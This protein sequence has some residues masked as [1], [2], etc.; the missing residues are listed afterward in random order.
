M[1][2]KLTSGFTST[3]LVI[4]LFQ[5]FAS[6]FVLAATKT[7]QDEKEDLYFQI[8]LESLR[9]KDKVQV[10]TR[11]FSDPSEFYG[12]EP[13]SVVNLH[14][15][16][17][18]PKANL[19]AVKSAFVIHKSPKF[20]ETNHFLSDDFLFKTVNGLKNLNRDTRDPNRAQM[21]IETGAFL[22]KV[23]TSYTVENEFFLTRQ[24]GIPSP[25]AT[26]LA[27]LDPLLTAPNTYATQNAF[28]FSA[29]FEGIANLSQTYELSSEETLVVNYQLFSILETLIH[30]IDL[31][32]FASGAG[33][34]ASQ[35][36][37]QTVT[38]AENTE[39]Y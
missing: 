20:F 17:T 33:L 8:D 25:I 18:H 19:L 35:T 9:H 27:T 28:G 2:K 10:A 12:V 34:F 38:A 5:L 4:F 24:S 15:Y 3:L 39:K 30:K 1:Q 31:I 37:K 16:E 36:K 23:Q 7:L 29:Y 6:P 13:F 14:H 11:F 22:I 32:P 26:I 21:S